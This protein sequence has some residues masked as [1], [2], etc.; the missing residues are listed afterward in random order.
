MRKTKKALRTLVPIG[1]EAGI[2]MLG[3]EEIM[4]PMQTII[5]NAAV[6]LGAQLFCA[7]KELQLADDIYEKITAISKNSNTGMI[8]DF[9]VLREGDEK[10]LQMLQSAVKN[11]Q[12]VR[13][14]C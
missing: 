1:L 12:V 9:S 14:L 11:K 13:F 6:G 8:L 10:L 5:A 4:S 2:A 3:L 7:E